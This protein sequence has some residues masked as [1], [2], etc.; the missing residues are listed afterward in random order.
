MVW[1]EAAVH[2]EQWPDAEN[3]TL[4]RGHHKTANAL[5]PPLKCCAASTGMTIAITGILTPCFWNYN[6]LC[7]SLSCIERCSSVFPFLCAGLL[8]SAARVLFKTHVT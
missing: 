1:Y 2:Y 3:R 8:L 7:G 4:R 5:L 6:R